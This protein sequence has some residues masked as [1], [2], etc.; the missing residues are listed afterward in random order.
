LPESAR[1]YSLSPASN[2]GDGILAGE[3]AAG[4][5]EPS[6][7]SAALWMPRSVMKADDGEPAMFPHILL[8]RAKPGLLAVDKTGRRFVHEAKSYHDVHRAIPHPN[9]TAP[10]VPAFLICD[11]SFVRDYGI[12]LVHPGTRNLDR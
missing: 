2:T 10:S 12:G 5:I 8:D 11:R 6:L 1:R 4:V 7:E 9:P 3:R